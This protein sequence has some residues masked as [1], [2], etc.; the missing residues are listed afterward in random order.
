MKTTQNYGIGNLP[1]SRFQARFFG[2]LNAQ[3]FPLAGKLRSL[4]D[5]RFIGKG[6]SEQ[7]TI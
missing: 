5:W 4:K 3:K 2:V 1:K 7:G 6:S